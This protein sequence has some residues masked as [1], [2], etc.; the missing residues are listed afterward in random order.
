MSERHQTTLSRLHEIGERQDYH[1]HIDAE[2]LEEIAQ[3]PFLNHYHAN[4]FYDESN[5]QNDGM[6]FF[7]DETNDLI[8]RII[9]YYC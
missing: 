8:R 7:Q 9:E 6:S 5:N 2:F 4:I 3:L 1:G